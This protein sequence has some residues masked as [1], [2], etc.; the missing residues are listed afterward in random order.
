MYLL[1]NNLVMNIA[2]PIFIFLISFVGLF[3]NANY[4][5]TRL[6]AK[7]IPIEELSQFKFIKPFKNDIY[8]LTFSNDTLPYLVTTDSLFSFDLGNDCFCMYYNNSLL[9]NTG[10][11]FYGDN[12]QKKLHILNT[13]KIVS[14]S[15]F[16]TTDYNILRIKDEY[17]S[18]G[19]PSIIQT[20]YILFSIDNDTVKTLT[21]LSKSSTLLDES[22]IELADELQFPKIYIQGNIDDLQVKFDI[23]ID[24]N[25]ILPIY[26]D[27]CNLWNEQNILEKNI[28]STDTQFW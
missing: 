6:Y 16:I 23:T 4:T 1:A 28:I 13:N 15:M 2:F 9:N 3:D 7:Y 17:N 10:H 11:V 18:F 19:T 20:K 22:N 24:N 8:A 14:I 27:N 12:I 25:F 5:F 21:L 26:F